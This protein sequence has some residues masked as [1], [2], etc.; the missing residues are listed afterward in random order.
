VGI[1][2]LLFF[3]AWCSRGG[4]VP[5][6]ESQDTIMSTDCGR[7]GAPRWS[8]LADK[9]LEERESEGVVGDLLGS[10]AGFTILPAAD[11]SIA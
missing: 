9:E 3:F 5:L 4:I 8:L 2:I 10:L 1:R 6:Q 7:G 11:P